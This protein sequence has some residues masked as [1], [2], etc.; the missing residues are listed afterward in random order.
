MT[1]AAMVVK[2]ACMSVVGVVE[3]AISPLPLNYDE[4]PYEGFKWMCMR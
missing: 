3:V 4:A 1:K 2:R